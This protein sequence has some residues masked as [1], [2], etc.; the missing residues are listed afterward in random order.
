MH[1]GSGRRVWPEAQRAQRVQLRSPTL[2]IT[3]RLPVQDDCEQIQS[4]PA[5]TATV[6][7]LFPSCRRLWVPT[8]QHRLA[9]ALA[10]AA[11]LQLR[12]VYSDSTRPSRPL[13]PILS[14][15]S[16][17]LIHFSYSL[18]RVNPSCSSRSFDLGVILAAIAGS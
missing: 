18:N 12:R 9:L 13:C 4:L 5:P 1:R 16:W 2:F 3:P 14:L 7:H 10:L 6:T 8:R 17:L 15:D 11:S